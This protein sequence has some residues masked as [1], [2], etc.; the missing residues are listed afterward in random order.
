[1]KLVV[2]GRGLAALTALYQFPN[3]DFFEEIV[4]IGNAP[5]HQKAS[6]YST[7]LLSRQGITRGHSELG[8]LLSESFDLAF[9]FFDRT[10]FSQ[11]H[12]ALHYHCDDEKSSFATR[13]QSQSILNGPVPFSIN[14]KRRVVLDCYMIQAAD[15]LAELEVRLTRRYQ[16]KI[17]FIN[18]HVLFID[19]DARSLSTKR[20]SLFQYDRLLVASGCNVKLFGIE[21]NLVDDTSLLQGKLVG[22]WN[23]KFNVNQSVPDHSSF[24]VTDC[25][26]NLFYHALLKQVVIGSTT[27][28]E[29][30]LA[31]S[32]S[33]LKEIFHYLKSQYREIDFPNELK[34]EMISGGVR[35]KGKKRLPTIKPISEDIFLIQGLYKNGHAFSFF[36]AKKFSEWA[37]LRE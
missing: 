16:Q 9:S 10:P 28:T 15:Y 37:L 17:S 2:I 7:G 14:E 34:A 30:I 6:F 23:L 31:P 1:M 8:D 33:K 25:G 5:F 32:L 27:E 18:D 26:I 29:N 36:G 22:G 11:V 20:G 4:V 19:G 13:Y 21:S 35:L 3:H 12:R 24:V